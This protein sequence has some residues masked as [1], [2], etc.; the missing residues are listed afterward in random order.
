MTTK[1][2]IIRA[3]LAA[4]FLASL[5]SAPCLPPTPGPMPTAMAVRSVRASGSCLVLELDCKGTYT[6]ATQTN[7]E[8]YG[9]CSQTAQAKTGPD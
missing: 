7:G 4:L 2:T 8:V 1:T 3:S 5:P 6:D 9:H